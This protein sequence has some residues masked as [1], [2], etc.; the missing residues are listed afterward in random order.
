MAENV[1]LVGIDGSPGGERALAWATAYAALAGAEVLAL[2]VLTYSQEMIQDL[3][4]IGFTTWRQRLE[5]D[6]TG[7][8][9]EG[10]VAAGVRHRCVL[11]EADSVDGGLNQVADDENV[12]LIV[13]GAHGHGN[14][15]DRMLGGVTYKVSHRACRP[16]VI[17]PVDWQP[18]MSA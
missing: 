12:S 17:V 7:R 9:T 15:A 4:P 16:V 8:W 10:L 14:L 3:P 5:D 18:P 13:L 6:L 11:T 2:H 1:V